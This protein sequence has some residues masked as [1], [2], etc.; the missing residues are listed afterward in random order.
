MKYAEFRQR[1]AKAKDASSTPRDFFCHG[2]L[3]R[4]LPSQ[5]VAR[6]DRLQRSISI[7]TGRTR[8]PGTYAQ[9]FALTSGSL[10]ICLGVPST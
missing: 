1:R 4:Y 7:F 2:R 8:P 6:G 5:R 10:M 9:V 3:L